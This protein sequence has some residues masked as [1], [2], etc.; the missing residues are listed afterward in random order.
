MHGFVSGFRTGDGFIADIF[1]DFFG[2]FQGG[3]ETLAGVGYFFSGYVS[4][5]GHQG[6]S[7][8]SKCAQVAAGFMF[9]FVGAFLRKGVF[10]F[11]IG[12]YTTWLTS[13]ELWGVTLP[14]INT[15]NSHHS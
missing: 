1:C 5:G 9:M 3:G 7:I 13:Y 2:A 12:G 8:F 15:I 14:A 10:P 4:G 11:L 6:A